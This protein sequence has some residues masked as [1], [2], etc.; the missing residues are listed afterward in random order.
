MSLLT[1]LIP[2]VVALKQFPAFSWFGYSWSRV[3]FRGLRLW[4]GV[5]L[6]PFFPLCTCLSSI[7][8]FGDHLLGCSHGPMRIRHHN[9]LVSILHHAL[10]QDH[11]GALKEQCASFDD[12]SRP[13]DIFQNGRP[14]YFDVSVCSTPL[15]CVLGWLLQLER[16]PR[17][18]STWLCWSSD[19][20]PLCVE[21]FGV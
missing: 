13:G 14:A 15:L 19:F 4:L 6:F 12:N 3:C 1:L 18:R 10:L 8:C 21:C 7:N 5:S 11:P 17:M 20:I 9:G 16:W 2:V